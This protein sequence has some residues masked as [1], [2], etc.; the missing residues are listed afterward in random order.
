MS[1][2]FLGLP[3]PF[4]PRPP[5]EKDKKNPLAEEGR[6]EVGPGLVL[7][8]RPQAFPSVATA[9]PSLSF[10]FTLFPCPSRRRWP[11]ARQGKGKGGKGRSFFSRRRLPHASFQANGTT[12]HPP[13]A[14]VSRP[15]PAVELWMEGGKAFGF[16]FPRPGQG[17]ALA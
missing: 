14:Q 15:K 1:W 16:F 5:I 4:S 17:F 2:F 11:K 6:R 3:L 12:F 13:T 9:R 10:P 8:H 7:R